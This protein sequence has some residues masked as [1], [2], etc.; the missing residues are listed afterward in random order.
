MEY[1]TKT[2]IGEGISFDDD[3]PWK[4]LDGVPTEKKDL[5]VIASFLDSVQQALV[6]IPVDESTKDGASDLHFIEEGRRMLIVSR[7]HVLSAEG[8]NRIEL[9][10]ELFT[11]CWSELAELKRANQADTGSLILLPG[12]DIQD[13]RKFT[14]MNLHLPLDWLG[15]SG[16]NLF[17]VAAFERDS[18]G[19]RILHRLSDIPKASQRKPETLS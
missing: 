2:G 18:P 8:K 15:V 6:E 5:N 17:E 4:Q 16:S 11:T 1:L 12:Y 14:E 13:L 10:D 9:Y 19:I 7:F 3:T